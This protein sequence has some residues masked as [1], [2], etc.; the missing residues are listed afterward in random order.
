M[1]NAL[2]LAA[3]VAT[4]AQ[5]GPDRMPRPDATGPDRAELDLLRAYEGAARIYVQARLPDGALGL[6]LV[7]TGANTSVLN[8]ETAA[9]LGLE[10]T[11]DWG[12]LSGLSG[13]ASMNHAVLPTLGLGGFA[14]EDIEVAVGAPGMG[15]QAGWMPLDGLL[16]TNV[17]SRFVM[18]LDYPADL[19]VL[20]RPGSTPLP[21]RGAS[22]HFDGQHVRAAVTVTTAADPPH[23]DTLITQVDTGASW[24][25]ICA[26]TGNRFRQD[27]TQGLEAVRGIGASETLP[28]IRFQQTTRRIPLASVQLGGVTIDATGHQAR[29]M[30]FEDTRSPTC[31]MGGMRALIGHYYL[32]DHRVFFDFQGGIFS[33]QKSHRRERE[34]NGHGVLL[35]QDLE[36]WG[37]DDTSRFLFRAQ[38]HI[39]LGDLDASRRLLEELVRSEDAIPAEDLAEAWV[40][41]ASLHREE[42][43]LVAAWEA[44]SHLEAGELVDQGEIVSAVNGLLF[45]DRPDD[46]MALADAARAERPD[47]ASAHVAR[48]DVLLYLGETDDAR[49]ELLE[50]ATVEEYPDAYLLRRARV[51]LAAGDRY[52][53]MAYVRRLIQLYPSVGQFLWFYAMLVQDEGEA[54]TFRRDMETAVARLHPFSRP[55]D[56]MVAAHHVLGDQDAAL[57]L[58]E[59]GLAAH[60]ADQEDEASRDNCYA[61]F[62]AL[63]G[64]HLDDALRRIVRALE[65]EGDRS[66]FLDTKAMVHLA[67]RE[68]D[69][70]KESAWSAARLRPDDVYMLWQAERIS[71]IRDRAGTEAAS[72]PAGHVA[73]SA[74]PPPPE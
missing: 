17:W 7:D 66:D 32:A 38:L 68:L 39:G 35:A 37:P 11:E 27:Y 59:E 71:D 46:A 45:E 25:T 48:A 72:V 69:D 56:F 9:R 26:A 51:A 42:G 2:M 34:L 8:P 64:V 3:L 29:W 16:G 33:L 44:L 54:A 20:H 41:L 4:V 60:C 49:A 65:V 24:L 30:E 28:P 62:Y 52:G 58:M 19:L 21:R 5:A 12:V 6:F 14:L 73:G 18:E 63:A 57:D 61:W 22:M 50:A 36:T 74:S 70:A 40:L 43:E 31:G 55:V 67:R 23:T 13:S 15:T 47:V 53:S 10:V 1:P